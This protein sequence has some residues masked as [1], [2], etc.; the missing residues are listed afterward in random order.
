[1][2]TDGVFVRLYNN[3]FETRDKIMLHSNIDIDTAM[4]SSIVSNKIDTI[5]ALEVL[6]EGLKTSKELIDRISDIFSDRKRMELHCQQYIRRKV[7]RQIGCLL[8]ANH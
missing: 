5:K 8:H 1:M 3:L 7:L 6:S 2:K 4:Q